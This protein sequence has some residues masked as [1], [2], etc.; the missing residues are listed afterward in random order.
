MHICLSFKLY[1]MA[2]TY[3]RD[4]CV[5]SGKYKIGVRYGGWGEGERGKGEG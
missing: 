1:V 3:F 2:K 5:K 4:Q